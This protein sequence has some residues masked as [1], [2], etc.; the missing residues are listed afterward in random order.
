MSYQIEIFH[1][2][3]KKLQQLDK[4][5]EKRVRDRLKELAQ[6]PFDH[7]ISDYLEMGEGRRYS[8]VGN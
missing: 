7:R 2:A 6:N 3:E 5:T 4:S 1:Q 8:R